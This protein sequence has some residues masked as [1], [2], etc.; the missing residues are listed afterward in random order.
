MRNQLVCGGRL[1]QIPGG[2]PVLRN[3]RSRSLVGGHRLPGGDHRSRGDLGGS[4]QSLPPGKESLRQELFAFLPHG[5][6]DPARR[7]T[8][9]STVFF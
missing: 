4:H 9:A 6:S 7:R 8:A 1:C 3:S 2:D 5:S